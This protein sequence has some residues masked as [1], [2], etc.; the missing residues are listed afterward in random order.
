MPVIKHK[1]YGLL[2][3]MIASVITN[4]SVWH[5][6]MSV[7]GH[8]ICGSLDML[9]MVLIPIILNSIRSLQYDFF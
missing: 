5:F 9:I 7:I 2:F 4:F 8:F 6:N 1:A 3:A